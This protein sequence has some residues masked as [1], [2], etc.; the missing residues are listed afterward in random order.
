MSKILFI[1]ELGSGLGHLTNLR[2]P[3]ECALNLGHDVFLAA[4][5][6]H[7]VKDVF[8]NK[9]IKYI[10]TPLRYQGESS[11]NELLSYSNLL[12]TQSFN[13]EVELGIQLEAWNFI[14]DSITPDLVIFE[15]SPKALI[16]AKCYQ[17]KKVILGTGFFIPPETKKDTDIFTIFPTT[18]KTSTVYL[19]LLE[20]DRRVLSLINNALATY[21]T[22]RLSKVSDI[23]SGVD[24]YYFLGYPF[25]DHFG[26]REGISYLGSDTIKSKNIPIWPKGKGKKVFA[27]IPYS[28]EFEGLL[29]SLKVSNN[30]VLIYG[31]SISTELKA[32]Y[33]SENISFITNI[34]DVDSI[35]DTADWVINQGGF[36][37][38]T[39]FLKKGIPQLIIPQHQE[40]LFFSM[41]VNA[42]GGCI[43]TTAGK[44][45][46]INEIRDM[47]SKGSLKENSLRAKDLCA[48]YKT[49][50]LR[51][52]YTES[53]KS[54]LN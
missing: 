54:L 40:S 50:D 4:R 13:N 33:T 15:H 10:Q 36:S 3:I 48:S 24:D 14:F 17:F 7:R 30:C 41:K 32:R 37:L 12:E 34:V 9:P 19:K 2:L 43:L 44:A 45:T 22:I 5:E 1:W 21:S 20:D 23:Y 52:F 31:A 27:Y 16:A 25:L 35:A 8:K 26:G 39:H 46:Y 53:I 42:L 6:L 38:V 29:Y 47:N 49:P 28:S 51:D 18:Q 11:T